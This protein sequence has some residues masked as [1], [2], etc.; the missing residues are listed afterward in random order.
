M[1]LTGLKS[2]CWQGHIPSEGS[3][4]EELLE[5]MSTFS[6]QRMLTFLGSQPLPSS[7]E[8]ATSRTASLSPAPLPPSFTSK[9]P[10]DYTGPRGIIR[11][12]LPIS[13]SA[14]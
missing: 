2:R 10:C 4:G 14:D 5:A 3:R 1:G 12:H 6:F 7:P 11:D 13:R 9:D 8:Q